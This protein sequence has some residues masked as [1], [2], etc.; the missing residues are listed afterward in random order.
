MS[1]PRRREFIVAI[2]EMIAKNCPVA[3][4]A[5]NDAI[6]HWRDGDSPRHPIDQGIFA[7]CD[8][9]AQDLDEADAGGDS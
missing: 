6:D 4:T 9:V 3:D 7:M 8:K 1:G 5:V 2:R